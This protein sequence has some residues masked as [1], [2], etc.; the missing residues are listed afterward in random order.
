MRKVSVF[1]LA[2]LGIAA[3]S[4]FSAVASAQA[5]GPFQFYSVTP[6]R[7][8]DTRNPPGITGGPALSHGATR[9]FPIHNQCGVPGGPTG[10]KAAVLNVT[11]VG[12]SNF[13]HLTIWPFN[14]AVPLVSTINFSAGEAALANGAI[15]PLTN[16]PSFNVSVS[17][18]IGGG[19]GSV[20]LII[21]V[22]G[23]FQ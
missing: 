9:S 23:Y 22:T 19:V 21:D 16:D 5:N 10:A 4:F 6:C 2:L 18:A 1:R 15:V 12:P 17:P 14:T 11:I 20:H 7:I 13:G 8:V 3:T